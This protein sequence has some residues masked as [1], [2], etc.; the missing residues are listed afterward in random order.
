MCLLT[1]QGPTHC[2]QLYVN[3]DHLSEPL[4]SLGIDFIWSISALASLSWKRLQGVQRLFFHYLH[5]LTCSCHWLVWDECVAEVCVCLRAWLLGWI[6]S[7]QWRTSSRPQLQPP[8][9]TDGGDASAQQC[10]KH[11]FTCTHAC[12]HGLARGPPTLKSFNICSDFD[13]TM[14]VVKV[15]DHISELHDKLH[16]S[17]WRATITGHGRARD[18]GAYVQDCHY[19][20]LCVLIITN[21]YCSSTAEQI[22]ASSPPGKHL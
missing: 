8:Q 9:S 3:K 16:W 2:A 11:T 19:K 10:W 7:G 17:P 22:S 1:Q 15:S 6:R 21:R 14:T 20:R 18:D 5:G 13:G 12:M 4:W